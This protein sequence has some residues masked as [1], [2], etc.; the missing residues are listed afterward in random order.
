MSV[1]LRDIIFR[2]A[3]LRANDRRCFYCGDVL[4]YRQLT[5]DHVVPRSSA[6]RLVR[7]IGERL[8]LTD[9]NVDSVQNLVPACTACNRSKG[10]RTEPL[11]GVILWLQQWAPRVPIVEA[12]IAVLSSAR[13]RDEVLTSLSVALQEQH[14]TPTDVV[15][16]FAPVSFFAMNTEPV[17][18]DFSTMVEAPT[19]ATGSEPRYAEVCDVLEWELVRAFASGLAGLVT[20]TEASARD[21]ECLGMRIAFWSE[22][23]ER[24]ADCLP[25]EWETFGVYLFSELYDCSWVPLVSQAVWIKYLS[26]DRKRRR[27]PPH[28]W[29]CPGC[30]SSLIKGS[31]ALG[32]DLECILWLRCEECRWSD[33]ATETSPKR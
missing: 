29:P 2:A 19:V 17:V 26:M 20:P 28:L 10:A 3:L 11:A 7:E 12:E 27:R 15:R 5:I 16:L 8:E 32:S 14:L 4:E 33:W 22:E 9:F 13:H 25:G 6:P 1:N 31:V 23:V 18:I 30:G 21:G 24:I